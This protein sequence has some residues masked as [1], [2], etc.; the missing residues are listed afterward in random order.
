MLK[1][2]YTYNPIQLDFSFTMNHPVNNNPIIQHFIKNG[3]YCLSQCPDDVSFLL[4]LFPLELVHQTLLTITN[5]KL[6]SSLNKIQTVEILVKNHFP[7]GI[8][9]YSKNQMEYLLILF[10]KTHPI[11][12]YTRLSLAKLLRRSNE[13][14]LC[15]RGC[16]IHIN[17]LQQL[18]YNKKKVVRTILTTLASSIN[19]L[20]TLHGKEAYY[21]TN[22]L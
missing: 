12:N 7:N 5:F 6:S 17:A 1:F 11:G 15:N 8:N 14:I 2:T 22:A 13:L 4:D 10:L 18:C 3:V 21:L 16:Y 20:E 19:K 9:T